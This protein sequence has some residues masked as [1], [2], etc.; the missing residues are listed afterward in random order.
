M[1]NDTI[2]MEG[3]LAKSSKIKYAFTLQF[4][5]TT[6]RNPPQRLTG[7]TMIQHTDKKHFVTLFNKKKT[8][9]NAKIY[10]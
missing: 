3:N 6:S 8:A 10:Q 7:K 4:S 2:F 5:N 9:N 1:Q